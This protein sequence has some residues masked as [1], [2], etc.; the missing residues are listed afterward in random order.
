MLVKFEV[1]GFEAT[2][3]TVPKGDERAQAHLGARQGVLQDRGAIRI[4]LSGLRF[5]KLGL[6]CLHCHSWLDLARINALARGGASGQQ[7]A[8]QQGKEGLFHREGL[9]QK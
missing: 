3:G 7:A 4:A 1:G 5:T 8:S 6:D 9:S 2:L